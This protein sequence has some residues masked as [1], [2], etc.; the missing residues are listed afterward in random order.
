MNEFQI[1]D[2]M[3]PCCKK[4]FKSPIA[5]KNHIIKTE[6][7]AH[8][9][10][11]SVYNE[12]HLKCKEIVDTYIKYQQYFE[13][14]D[15]NKKEI[16]LN[17]IEEDKKEQ[18]EKEFNKKQEE[19]AQRKLEQLRKEGERLSQLEEMH[20]LKKKQES[21]MFKDLP[22]K[23]R[24][25]ALIN[26]FYQM[27]HGQCF[28]YAIE[29]KL[30]KS[31]F[32]KNNF[33]VM[34]VRN[35]LKY[36]ANMGYA[37]LRSLNYV[38]NDACIFYENVKKIHQ[39][40]TIPFLIQYYYK[41]LKMKMNKKYFIKEIKALES[42]QRA[43]DLTFEEMK[44]VIDGMIKEKIKVLLWFDGNV[45]KYRNYKKTLNPCRAYTDEREINEVVEQVKYGKMRLRDI[46]KRIYEPCLKKLKE[47]YMSGDF[48]TKY[49][50]F[51]WAFKIGLTLDSEMYAVGKQNQHNRKSR[52]EALFNQYADN[53]SNI[54]KI[55]RSKKCFDEWLTKQ[56]TF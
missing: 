41:S 48:D 13:R 40:G 7:E 29:V 47:A 8:A 56:Y 3:C 52:F 31:L 25:N 51:E 21:R 32:T 55:N 37:N 20:N 49:T 22:E 30:V 23:D 6:D 38:L 50:H 44:N 36:M 4:K 16:I 34:Q 28:N 15:T 42:S 24:P 5:M 19:K 45:A 17:K 35:V 27:I 33:T 26:E 14:D 54:E 9:L 11:A 39:E 18:K 46:S 53:A 10:L 2:S 1:N 12:A 43:N